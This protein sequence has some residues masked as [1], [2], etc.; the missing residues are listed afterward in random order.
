MSRSWNPVGE[1]M[2]R[3][4]SP[5]DMVDLD[6]VGSLCGLGQAAGGP[7]TSGLHFFGDEFSAL[8]GVS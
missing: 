2:S 7:I 6:V 4:G 8:A 5:T 1:M 3:N